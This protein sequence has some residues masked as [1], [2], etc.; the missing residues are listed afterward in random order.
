MVQTDLEKYEK[1]LES[2]E[3]SSADALASAKK[4]L[5]SIKNSKEREVGIFI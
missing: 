3:K 5:Q 1:M 4:L 2:A